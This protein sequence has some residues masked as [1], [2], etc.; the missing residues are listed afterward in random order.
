MFQWRQS[1]FCVR[2][3]MVAVLALGEKLIPMASQFSATDMLSAKR[4]PQIETNSF[5]R[6]LW[7]PGKAIL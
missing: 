2:A 3:V 6:V 5:H 1:S 4:G 7:T